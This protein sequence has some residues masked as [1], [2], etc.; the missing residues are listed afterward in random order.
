MWEHQRKLLVLEGFSKR[1]I[2]E[3]LKRLKELERAIARSV[4]HSKEKD[5]AR[6]EKIM[7]DYSSAHL[8]AS[9]DYFIMETWDETHS[10]IRKIDLLL[11]QL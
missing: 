5:D 9:R 4:Q 2:R 6:G 8:S 11:Q 3:N 10:A 1:T 7:S